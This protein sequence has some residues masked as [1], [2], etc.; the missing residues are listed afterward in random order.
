ML[1]DRQVGVRTPEGQN[2][3][4]R[5]EPS[6]VYNVA[7]MR[8]YAVEYTD[9]FG[10]KHTNIAYVVGNTVYLDPNGERWTANL[11][12]ANKYVLDAVLAAQ[13]SQNTAIPSKDH[14]DVLTG[15]LGA[16]QTPSE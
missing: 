7:P 3:A 12:Q 5:G 14:V 10:A 8:L 2:S 4:G 6:K 9:E 13:P 11:K 1:N 15:G 16:D